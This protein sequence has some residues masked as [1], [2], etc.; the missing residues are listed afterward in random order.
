MP[1]PSICPTCLQRYQLADNLRGKR[2]RCRQCSGSFVVGDNSANEPVVV[3]TTA[4]A[5][6]EDAP[7]QPRRSGGD[8]NFE[9]APALE[10]QRPKR[11]KDNTALIVMIVGGG[12]AACAIL[13]AAVAVWLFMGGKK[14]SANS[15][16]WPPAGVGMAPAMQPPRAQTQNQPPAAAPS[17]VPPAPAAKT[18]PGQYGVVLSNAKMSSGFAMQMELTIDY[19]FDKEKPEPG[20]RGYY[21]VI[22][23]AR[24]MGMY[25]ANFNWMRLK[26]EGTLQVSGINLGSTGPYEVYM[27]K[28]ALGGGGPF[29]S[30]RQII[31][32]IVKVDAGDEFAPPFGPPR[33][34]PFGGPDK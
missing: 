28:A 27:E 33:M 10:R 1:I 14:N 29:G 7:A 32:N 16:P 12:V 17:A 8:D 9:K 3:A 4:I 6:D 22:K 30:N 2:V 15:Q 31:S 34:P 5:D 25:E 19:R 18:A 24:G 21:L 11:K 13:I 20:T 23:P 26:N